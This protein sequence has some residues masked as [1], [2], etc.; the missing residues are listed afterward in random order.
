MHKLLLLTVT[1]LLLGGCGAWTQDQNFACANA[2]ETVALNIHG[3]DITIRDSAL[4]SGSYRVCWENDV[5]MHFTTAT[6]AKG[7]PAAEGAT[8]VGG[9]NTV[10]RQL[11]LRQA[12][13]YGEYVCREA[14][15]ANAG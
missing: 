3:S 2:T 8:K 6:V 5:Q 1:S 10:T 9:Y 7:C 14:K 11:A 4:F 13:D 15:K 12:G